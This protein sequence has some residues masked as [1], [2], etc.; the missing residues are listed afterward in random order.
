M[1]KN[2]PSSRDA[3][4][5]RVDFTSLSS[6]LA[7][8]AWMWEFL[9]YIASK[10]YVQSDMAHYQGQPSFYDR[11]RPALTCRQAVQALEARVCTPVALELSD[12]AR[13]HRPLLSWN[14]DDKIQSFRNGKQKCYNEKCSGLKM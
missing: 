14:Q 2:V 13:K 6:F 3:S 7:A 8:S 4:V 1:S 9:V 11:A 12:M 10:L 5:G